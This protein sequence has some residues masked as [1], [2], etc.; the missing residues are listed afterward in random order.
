MSAPD[1]RKD[2]LPNFCKPHPALC[3]QSGC[4]VDRGIDAML[5][6]VRLDRERV[7]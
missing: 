7:R 5:M 3:A 2:M 4:R 1:K 6:V